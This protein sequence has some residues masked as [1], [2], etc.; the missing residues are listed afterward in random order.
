MRWK[1]SSAFL[2]LATGLA[3]AG[4]SEYCISRSGPSPVSI[5]ILTSS[6]HITRKF[7]AYA[8]VRYR[9]GIAFDEPEKLVFAKPNCVP[10]PYDAGN[11]CS[12]IPARCKAPWTLSQGNA[13]IQHGSASETI[14]RTQGPP[15]LGLGVFQS[16]A[17][18]WYRLDVD[19]ISYQT[20][21]GQAGPRLIV[22]ISTEKPVLY[23]PEFAA[24]KLTARSIYGLFLFTGGLLIL[25]S[26]VAR[27]EALFAPLR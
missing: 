13:T 12:G 4:F 17:W 16:K 9:I 20:Q 19:D 27:R 7:L 25:S 14:W 6:P 8:N 15:F 11:D 26:L 1:L 10:D 24:L 21:V 23:G 5:P 22:E 18:Q 3:F 2:L